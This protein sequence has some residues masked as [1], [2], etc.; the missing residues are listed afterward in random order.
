VSTDVPRL[1][2][3]ANIL[4]QSPRLDSA[5]W[6]ALRR[7]GEH[8]EVELYVPE[9][10][11]VEAIA[12]WERAWID[13]SAELEK[14]V[15]GLRRLGARIDPRQ[16][17]EA[18]TPESQED[19]L[20]SRLEQ[21]GTVLPWP[22]VAHEQLVRRAVNRRR[23]FNEQ[24]SGYRDALIWEQVCQLATIGPVIFVTANSRDFGVAPDL[25]AELLADLAKR[26]IPEDQ[27]ALRSALDRLISEVI[28]GT[29]GL[30]QALLPALRT[31]AVLTALA[32]D[33]SEDM[34]YSEGVPFRQGTATL[35]GWLG[36]LIAEGV[37]TLSNLRLLEARVVDTDGY[38]VSGTVDG[39]TTLYSFVDRDTW[40]SL[41][42]DEQR[43]AISVT[44]EA[45]HQITVWMD[46]PATLE[47]Q[48]IF[49]PDS[50]SDSLVG[51]VT[52]RIAP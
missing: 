1:V 37:R 29:E 26:K 14:V 52:G 49:T 9:I 17:P 4:I 27:V 43:R 8:G 46:Q 50:I 39:M 34:M 16:S 11:V 33:M 20:R 44:D 10:C 51:R 47:F 12:W 31:S 30:S 13:K 38:F 18:L 19:Y 24:G 45:E 22:D 25:H 36:D 21:A 23:P 2:L 42:P 32:E 5:S 3:D 28:G 41:D 40:Y 15:S 35:P 7:A 48:A 6:R